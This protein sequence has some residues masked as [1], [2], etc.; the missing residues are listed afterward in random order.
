M[1]YQNPQL[2]YALFAIAIPII[3]HLF[4]LRKYKTIR[5]S[6][7]RFL[8]QIKKA[9]RSRARL[10]NVL[11][12]LSRILAIAALILAF[13]KPYLPLQVTQKPIANDIFFY[14]DNFYE[15]VNFFA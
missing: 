15:M 10:K 6:S 4:N 2:L 13:S 11:I 7:V 9:K 8:R 14:I 3:I 12:L 1:R 5:F